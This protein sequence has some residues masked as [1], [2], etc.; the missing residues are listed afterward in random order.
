MADDLIPYRQGMEFGIGVDTPSGDSRNVGV[1]GEPT[2]IPNASGSI[3]TF[4]VKQVSSDEDLQTSLGVSASAGGGVGL[5]SASASMNFAQ[6]CHIHSNSVFLV[7]SVDVNLAF[8]QIRSPKIDPAAAAKLSDGD[9]TRFQEMYGDSFIRGMQTGGR[10]FAVAEIMTSTK[11]EQESLSISLKGSYGPFAAQGSFSSEFRSAVENKSMKVQ[12]HYE[13][14]VVPKV[15]TGIDEIQAVASTFA[16]SVEGHGVPYAVLLDRYSILD[17]PRPPNYVDLQNQMDVLAYC[18]QQR[19]TIWTALNNLSYVLANPGQFPAMDTGVLVTYRQALETD[20]LS[21]RKAASLA[22]DH[23]RDAVLPVLSAQPMS[24]PDRSEGEIDAL[25]AQ[26]QAMAEA[27]PLIAAIRDAQ[28]VGPIRRGFYVGLGTEVANTLWGPGAQ[29][30]KDSLDGAEQIGFTVGAAFCLD[31]N[32]NKEMTARGAAVLAADTDL[33]AARAIEKT[34]GLYWLGFEIGTG[35]FGD[36]ALGAQGNT[37]WGPGAERIQATLH[38][39]SQRG[40]IAARDFNW[41]KRGLTG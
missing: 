19:N 4:A 3:V 9:S 39:D 30:I 27:D 33:Q 15:P 18:A 26:G 21:V 22:L 16:A 34:P 1:L 28:P 36:P 35:I 24:M 29:S 13:G 8:T 38:P 23:P 5:F 40:F 41:K 37:L 2:S 32:N 20:L 31:R 10:F 6:S 14:G 25:A 11:S 7:A 17:I 12:I